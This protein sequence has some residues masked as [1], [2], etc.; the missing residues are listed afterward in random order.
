MNKARNITIIWA[1]DYG[2]QFVN[3]DIFK[4]F[5]NVPAIEFYKFIE[6]NVRTNRN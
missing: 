2:W 3:A 4:A 5:I 6:Y 1:K